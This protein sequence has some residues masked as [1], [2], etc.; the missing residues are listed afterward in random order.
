MARPRSLGIASAVL[1]GLGAIPEIPMFP[2]F[3]V[4]LVL[5]TAALASREET[6]E[7]QPSAPPLETE[8]ESLHSV[9]DVDALGVE[10]GYGLIALVDE[11]Q[12]GSLL[13]RIRAIR[14]QIATETGVVVPPVRVT[15]N[16]QLGPRSYTLSVKGIEVGRGELQPERFLAINPGTA[17]LELQGSPTKEPAFGLPA[18]WVDAGHR[19]AASKAGYTVV[20][21]TT[22]VSTHLSETVRAFLPDLLT[23]QQVKEML[24]HVAQT[25]GDVPVAVE[26]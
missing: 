15:D 3:I 8:E 7:T 9:I 24:D 6:Q 21:P 2:F 13:P 22:A 10:V 19:E 11:K 14:R 4:S 1:F 25:D 23:R 26:I 20:D 12:G 18:W 16:L 17:T 5:G